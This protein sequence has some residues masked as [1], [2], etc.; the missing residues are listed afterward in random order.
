MEMNAVEMLS[1]FRFFNFFAQ[2]FGT[3]RYLKGQKS[4]LTHVE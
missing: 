4:K 1:L 2:I 3:N